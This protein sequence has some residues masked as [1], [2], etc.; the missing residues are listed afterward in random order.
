[1]IIT[2]D[3]ETYYDR[4]FS[5]SKMTTEEYIRSDGFE[6]I[7]VGVKVDEGETAWFS[8]TKAETQEFLNQYDWGNSLVLAHNTA[9]DGAIL[10]WHFGVSP[11]AWLDTLCMARA[12]HGVDVGGSLKALAE[13]YNLG[14]KG[15]EVLNALGKRRKDF[16]PEDLA[17]Y[18]EYCKNDVELTYNLFHTLMFPVKNLGGGAFPKSELKV[19]DCTLRMFT[20]PE[21]R[22]DLPLLEQHLHDVKVKKEKLLEAAAANRDDLMSND[23]FA[24]LLKQLG[25]EPPT[26]ISPKTNKEAW[27]FAKTDEAFKELA[28]HPDP[29][30]QTLVAARLG[31]KTTLE[32]TR[33]QRFIDIAKRGRMPV[34]LKY[35]AAHT[36]RWGGDDKVNLQNLPSRGQNA[37]K[38]KS[39]IRP[40]AGYVLIDADSSQIEA[41][42]V[43]WLSGQT[44]LV[45]AFEKG[46][47]V[48]KIMASKIYRKSVEEIS[49]D[50]RFVGKTTILGCIAEGTL[51]LCESGWKPIETVSIDDKVWDGEEW[52]CHQGLLNK[53]LKET[54]NLSGAWLTPDHKVLCGTQWLETQSVVVDENTLYQA[55]GTGAASLPLQAISPASEVGY[56]HLLSNARVGF[57]NI[58]SMSTTSKILSPHV[59]IYAQKEPRMRSGTGLIPKLCLTINIERGFSIDSLLQSLD[60]T[61]LSPN[62]TSTMGRG[63]SRFATNGATIGQRFLNMFRRSKVGT[64]RNMKWIEPTTIQ[65]TD[66][67]TFGLSHDKIMSTIDEALKNCKRKL[68]TYDLAYAGPRNRFTILTNRGPVI[69]HNCGYG[70][71]PVKFGVQLKTFGVT[72]T[73]DEAKRIIEVYRQTYDKIPAL[74]KQ[75]QNSLEA[76]LTDRTADLGKY[77]DA[78]SVEGKQ[79]IRLPSGLFLRYPELTK[80]SEGQFAYKTRAGF[81]KIYGGKV[82][83]NVCQAVARCIIAEQ[84]LLIGKKYKVV[85]TVHDA[86]ACIAP[87]EEAETAVKYVEE[88]MRFRPDWCKDLPLNCEVGYG[89][90]YGET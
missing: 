74:W 76:I 65:A 34:P 41:R 85:L 75:A 60:A 69:V 28:S 43:A 32:E 6:V 63:E 50:E 80:D 89:E 13:R 2:V 51:V 16:C 78:L 31:N 82:I 86:V 5:L 37:G 4:E 71:G 62:T 8:G 90:N 7:G 56:A 29:R 20:H 11:K 26:K 42:T 83:E 67:E 12:L 14:E 17:K 87:K 36:G 88:C 44:D 33:T 52:V 68:Q 3:F 30:V 79:G 81:T 73:E 21:L 19:I 27:A 58:P 70:M 54:L 84:M 9:F 72:V 77:P 55:L 10:S 48:Y 18:G 59:A 46:E 22:L 15:T 39:A 53:G 61:T 1:M 66:P 24:D 38:L 49:K 45:D 40:P 35:Y 47:D 57:L 64:T 25:V 23:K